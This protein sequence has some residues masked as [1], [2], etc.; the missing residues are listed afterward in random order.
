MPWTFRQVTVAACG[1]QTQDCNPGPNSSYK[2]APMPTNDVMVTDIPQLGNFTV[3]QMSV[4]EREINLCHGWLPAT[5]GSRPPSNHWVQWQPV[6]SPEHSGPTEGQGTPPPGGDRHPVSTG[7]TEKLRVVSLLGSGRFWDL[8]VLSYSWENALS[9]KMSCQL[10]LRPSE[11]ILA[12]SITG[13][14]C[15]KKLYKSYSVR[16]CLKWQIS[17]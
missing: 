7:G 6:R 1:L 8:N 14:F 11:L 4:L 17:E 2:I 5:S 16:E 15:V 13:S 9:I 12:L 10:L 3:F